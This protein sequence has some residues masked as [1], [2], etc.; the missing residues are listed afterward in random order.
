MSA[1]G[2]QCL[3]LAIIITA[4]LTAH[5]PSSRIKIDPETDDASQETSQIASKKFVIIQCSMKATRNSECAFT[6]KITQNK[7]MA[8]P[9]SSSTG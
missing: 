7:A 4:A 3:F 9:L 8:F 1:N 6:Y 5:F 2:V